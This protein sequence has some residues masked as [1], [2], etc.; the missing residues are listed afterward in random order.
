[1][2]DIDIF[3]L[4]GTWSS[5]DQATNYHLLLWVMVPMSVQ[6]SKAL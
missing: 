3:V 2:E 1:M 6:F 5:Q 4:A